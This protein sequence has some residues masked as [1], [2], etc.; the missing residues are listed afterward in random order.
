M[1][2]KK[3]ATGTPARTKAAGRREREHRHSLLMQMYAAMAGHFGPCRWWPG[4]SPFEVAVGAVLT[5]NTAW[6]NVEKALDRLRAKEA[7]RPPVLWDMPPDVLEEALRPSGFF[8]LKARR[9]R[10]LLNYMRA[11]PG[12]DCPPG[13]ESLAF[14]RT[15]PG[16]ELR[17]EL[18]AISGIG[19]ETADCILLYALGHPSFVADAYTRRIF[20]RHGLLP[21]DAPYARV[22][23]FFMDALPLDAGLFNEYHALIVRT[24]HSFCKKSKPLCSQCPLQRFS[25]HA[26]A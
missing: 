12:W 17:Q 19:P 1:A 20:S 4:D 23:D 8:R 6:R 15:K 10:N 11:F 21:E 9:L 22:R 24:G 16:K 13:D 25:R 2:G 26:P 18:L 7:L 5:Q 14:M 3:E